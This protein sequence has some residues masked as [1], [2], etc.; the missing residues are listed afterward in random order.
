MYK[1]KQYRP[2][3]F[4]GF[5]NVIVEFNTIEEFLNID[6][7]TNFTGISEHEGY[8]SEGFFV[9]EDI[10]YIFHINYNPDKKR[11][12][13]WGV[14]KILDGDYRQLKEIFFEKWGLKSLH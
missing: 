12:E 3:Y 9:A 2:N 5:E 11:M 10:G 6:F 4:S 8:T 13:Q 1:I 7:V 14:A